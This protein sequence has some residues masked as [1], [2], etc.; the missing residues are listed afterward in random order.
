MDNLKLHSSL[1]KRH[2]TKAYKTKNTTQKTKQMS[3]TN[4][5]TKHNTE[6]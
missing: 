4:P 3:N 2:R 5:A 6:N 1:A